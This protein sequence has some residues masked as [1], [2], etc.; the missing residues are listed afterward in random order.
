[1]KKTVM[2][3]QRLH[4]AGYITY[5]RADSTNLSVDATGMVHGFIEDGFGQKY[6]P[7]KVNVYSS[8]EGAQEVHEA[9]RPSDVNLK[10]TQLPDMERGAGCLHDLI[11][12]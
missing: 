9:V 2:M 8:K 12:C 4:K 5:M 3:T 11:W 6:L 1:M 7:G 10:P